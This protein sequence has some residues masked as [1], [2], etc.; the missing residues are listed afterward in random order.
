MAASNRHLPLTVRFGQAAP[1]VQA[2]SPASDTGAG[3]KLPNRQLGFLSGF[4]GPEFAFH[5]YSAGILP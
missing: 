4:P 1:Q 3:V 2:A 5:R